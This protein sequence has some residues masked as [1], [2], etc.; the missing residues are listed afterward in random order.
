M[1]TFAGLGGQG[2]GTG[3]NGDLTWT[4]SN[5][6]KPDAVVLLLH[7]ATVRENQQRAACASAPECSL[8]SLGVGEL[9]R[10]TEDVFFFVFWCSILGVLL[11]GTISPTND[12]R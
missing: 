11:R 2:Q 8:V 3:Q 5:L 9:Q 12:S 6:P 1:S 7:D 4:P 10:N